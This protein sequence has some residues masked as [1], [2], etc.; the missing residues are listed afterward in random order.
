MKFSDRERRNGIVSCAI[1]TPRS[2]NGML[3]TFS[4]SMYADPN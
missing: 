2:E 1:P 4:V 3:L